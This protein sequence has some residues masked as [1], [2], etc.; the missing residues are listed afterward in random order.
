MLKMGQIK[1]DGQKEYQIY[2]Q[3]RSNKNGG[4]L[5]LGILKD[6]EPVWL[7]DGGD[8]V[9]ALTVKISLDNS[10]DIRLTNAYG[11]Q[12]YDNQDKKDK[13]WEYLENEVFYCKNEGHGCL[14][15][16]D[17]N[18]WLGPQIIPNDLHSM[19]INGKMFDEF[20]KRN[21]HMTVLN[22]TDM[23]EGSITRVRKVNDTEEKSIID[24]ILVCDKVIPYVTKMLIDEEKKYA[25][26]NFSSKNKPPTYSDY[27]TIIVDINLKIKK[28][29]PERKIVYNNKY[30]LSK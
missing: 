18:A 22:K 14:M 20:L 15:M 1:F 21:P 13:F 5:A 30:N 6:L 3:V 11:P 19:N 17:S 28:H 26:M 8:L 24:F 27:N 25:V 2:E 29:I 7:K 23:C 9:E 10:I 4:G 12:V 16:M